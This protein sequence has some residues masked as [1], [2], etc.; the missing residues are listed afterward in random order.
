MA[1]V[2]PQDALSDAHSM[3]KR[4]HGPQRSLDQRMDALERA[5][6]IRIKRAQL[7]VI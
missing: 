1:T 5:N 6:E 3:V 2:H 4:F 7:S